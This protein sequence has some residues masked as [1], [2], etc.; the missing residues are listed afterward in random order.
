MNESKHDQETAEESA[1]HPADCSAHDWPEDFDLDN[2]NY[3][4]SCFKCG[5]YFRGHKNRWICKECARKE[6]E[7]FDRLTQEQKD[8]EFQRFKEEIHRELSQNTEVS[9]REK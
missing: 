4:H 1:S 7:R 6:Q 2:G 9:H 8:E 3:A 5:I